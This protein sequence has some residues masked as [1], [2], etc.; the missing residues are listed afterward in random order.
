MNPYVTGSMI[1]ALREKQKLTQAAL[2][3]KLCVSEKTISKWETGKGYPD[4][5]ILE[6]LASSLHVSVIEL[7]SGVPISNENTSFNM[8]KLKFYVCP[9]CGNILT[10]AGEAMVSCHGIVLPPLQAEEV[11]DNHTILIEP[12]EDEYY[13]TVPHPMSKSHY[14]SFLAAV[15]DDRVELIK[16]YPEGMAEC[17]FKR[18]RTKEI[19]AFCNRHGLFKVKI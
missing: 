4:I 6:D 17:R 2:A 3:E 11:D 5:S 12:V 13:V 14:I 16:L 19:Y 10:S 1:K 7:M 18:S 15:Q 9:V 8:R